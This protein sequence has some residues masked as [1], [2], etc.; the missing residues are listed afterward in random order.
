MSTKNFGYSPLP[1]PSSQTVS[2]N[3]ATQGKTGRSEPNAKDRATD[4][5]WVHAVQNKSV[6]FAMC[7]CSTQV[8]TRDNNTFGLKC[9]SGSRVSWNCADCAN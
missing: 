3:C 7:T 9:V 4:A 5:L 8:F 2:V 1:F 6:F